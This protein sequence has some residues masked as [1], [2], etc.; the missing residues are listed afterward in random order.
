MSAAVEE[1]IQ[2]TTVLVIYT[3]PFLILSQN[4]TIPSPQF[5]EDAEALNDDKINLVTTALQNA[6]NLDQ[7]LEQINT[8]VKT[9]HVTL[10][11]DVASPNTAHTA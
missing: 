1:N 2:T 9:K 4:P 7:F 3:S 10:A 8:P 11:I 6:D 5:L